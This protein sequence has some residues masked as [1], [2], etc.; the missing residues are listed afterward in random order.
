MS[1]CIK[2]PTEAQLELMIKEEEAMRNSEWYL[3]ECTKVA[4]IPD[5]WLAV[6]EKIQIDIVRTNGFHDQVSQD[7]AINY[8]RRAPALYPNNPVF[9]T[10]VYVRYNKAKKG[11]MKVGDVVK[12][13]TLNDM[14]GKE[15]N[16]HDLLPMND[17]LTII[18]ASSAT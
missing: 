4:D 18:I 16:L 10:P 5:G 12:N 13:L 11:E 15:I 6:S 14:D 17:Q 3:N 2:I 7:M 1:T 9:Q 8:L